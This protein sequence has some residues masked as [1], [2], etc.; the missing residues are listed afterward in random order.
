ML[1]PI[2]IFA[3]PSFPGEL[4]E[5]ILQKV[6][7]K[8]S[9][10][11]LKA[12]KTTRNYILKNSVF[13]NG[14]H[15][16]KIK[17][18][19]LDLEGNHLRACSI[20]FIIKKNSEDRSYYFNVN[21]QLYTADPK[22]F[23]N[24]GVVRVFHIENSYD[25]YKSNEMPKEKFPEIA[26]HFANLK[27]VRVMKGLGLF[28]PLVQQVISLF[29]FQILD[30][31][32]FNFKECRVQVK[33]ITDWLF[34]QGKNCR[35]FLLVNLDKAEVFFEEFQMEKD[36]QKL[37]DISRDLKEKAKLNIESFTCYKRKLTNEEVGQIILA[38]E[39]EIEYDDDY[40][41]SCRDVDGWS[42]CSD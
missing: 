38:T 39:R 11:L 21:Q 37:S 33:T 13:G 30:F 3:F 36:P 27:V 40:T 29:P 10:K 7:V 12:S 9:L 25:Y 5:K 18:D 4:R 41:I 15:L 35:L 24:I 14:V 23:K 2:S 26:A 6:D 16:I 19:T 31:I 17:F 34:E 20:E 28:C 22:L 8:A 1:Q 32:K 42:N